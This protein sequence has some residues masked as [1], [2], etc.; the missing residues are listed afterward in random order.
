MPGENE[1]LQKVLDGIEYPVTVL[2]EGGSILAANE[3]WLCL[4][5]DAGDQDVPFGPGADY[6]ACYL[7]LCGVEPGSGPQGRTGA[8]QRVL[9]GRG[10]R[11]YWEHVCRGSG[12]ERWV[13]ACA[14]PLHCGGAVITLVDTGEQ[15]RTRQETVALSEKINALNTAL[16][17]FMERRKRDRREFLASVQASLAALVLPYLAELEAEPLTPRQRNLLEIARHNL[18]DMETR[19]FPPAMPGGLTPKESRVA[20]LVRRGKTSREIAELLG[21]S[22]KTVE[23]HRSRL[24]KKLGLRGR[25]SRLLPSLLYR[26]ERDDPQP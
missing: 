17:V 25:A 8:L 7:R 18:A 21:I 26:A 1:M 16:T 14:S 22:L 19:T 11:E 3:A 9:S 2:D 10:G 13:R 15:H 23:Y 20:D 12:R 5:R 6:L 4:G 24:R